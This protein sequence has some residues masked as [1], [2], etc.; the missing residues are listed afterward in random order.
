MI[1]DVYK[2]QAREDSKLRTES[3]KGESGTGLT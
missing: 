3:L 2:V 1:V